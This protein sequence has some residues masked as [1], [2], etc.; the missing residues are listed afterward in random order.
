MIFCFLLFYLKNVKLTSQLLFTSILNLMDSKTKKQKV[1]PFVLFS[2][3]HTWAT[4]TVNPLRY[5]L[6]A[7]AYQHTQ[8]LR[9][10]ASALQPRDRVR[11]TTLLIMSELQYRN[12]Y[13]RAI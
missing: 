3:L 6:P 12:R 13:S 2:I 9:N 8:T 11:T 10:S 7:T 1:G 4:I 5:P